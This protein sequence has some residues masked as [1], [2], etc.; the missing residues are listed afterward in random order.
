[1]YTA[2]EHYPPVSERTLTWTLTMQHTGTQ[3][4]KTTFF[5][6]H[7]NSD[8]WKQWYTNIQRKKTTFFQDHLNSDHWKQWHTK[9]QRKK[10]TF[11]Q[12]HLN[13]NWLRTQR[14][15]SLIQHTSSRQDMNTADPQKQIKLSFRKHLF[16]MMIETLSD[17]ILS[18]KFHH[19]L[20]SWQHK[21]LLLCPILY[22][23]ERKEENM[24]DAETAEIVE[25]PAPAPAPAATLETVHEWPHSKNSKKVNIQLRD[26][27]QCL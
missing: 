15:R 21:I 9:T 17:T 3:R 6:D 8:H 10:P 26:T 18:V 23:S 20:S 22:F 4:K 16:T 2:M 1:M 13:S 5:Q 25:G 7:L 12:D 19:T 14:L 27:S 11:F 24:E